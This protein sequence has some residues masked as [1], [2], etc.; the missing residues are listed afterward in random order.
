[1]VRRPVVSSMRSRQTGHVGSSTREG[2]GGASG[3][4]VREEAMEVASIGEDDGSGA[5]GCFVGA[6]VNGSFVRSG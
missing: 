3:L 4:V 6:G 5:V 1:M 2:V